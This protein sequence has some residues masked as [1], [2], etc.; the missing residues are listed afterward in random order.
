MKRLFYY[1]YL[2]GFFFFSISAFAQKSDSVEA[3]YDSLVIVAFKEPF[4]AEMSISRYAF[5]L[6]M[7]SGKNR[8][9]TTIVRKYDIANFEYLLNTCP[10]LSYC[11]PT[12]KEI[13]FDIEYKKE[14]SI[15]LSP[16]ND[17]GDNRMLIIMFSNTR[18]KY[19]WCTTNGFYKDSGYYSYSE[20]LLK[21]LQKWTMCLE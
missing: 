19:L 6:A 9:D 7:Q 15:F 5:L 10:K 16:R 18:K 17:Q 21:F 13:I 2:C 14:E 4:E 11:F 3:S 8:M 12:S 20:K 1:M